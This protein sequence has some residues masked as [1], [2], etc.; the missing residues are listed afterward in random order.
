MNHGNEC[1]FWTDFNKECFSVRVID[2][3]GQPKHKKSAQTII[4]SLILE[5]VKLTISEPK[6]SMRLRSNDA[7][8][9]I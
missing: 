4:Q 7:F 9:W 5:H 1:H 8:R 3:F 6:R 2:S